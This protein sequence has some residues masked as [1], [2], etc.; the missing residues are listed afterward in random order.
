MTTGES[1]EE[2]YHSAACGQLSTD[3]TGIITVVNQTFLDWSG[4]AREDIVGVPLRDLLTRGSQLFYETRYLPVLR[5]AGEVREVALEMNRGDGSVLPILV[6]ARE[7]GE[8][9]PGRR[10]R[11]NPAAGL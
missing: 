2:L 1:F 11:F 6:N 5:L 7:V 3:A 8:R 4:R 10:L 9:D